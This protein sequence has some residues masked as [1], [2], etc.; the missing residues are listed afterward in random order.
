M[1]S[2]FTY[3]A[4][5]FNPLISTPQRKVSQEVSY[6]HYRWS[7][8]L[9]QPLS[10]IQSNRGET[11]IKSMQGDLVISLEEATMSQQHPDV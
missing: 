4:G 8:L 11:E 10:Y 6:H 1:S 3:L 7:L 5:G 9:F 2:L